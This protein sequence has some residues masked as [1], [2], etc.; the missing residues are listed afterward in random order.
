MPRGYRLLLPRFRVYRAILRHADRKRTGNCYASV[1]IVRAHAE[2]SLSFCSPSFFFFFVRDINRKGYTN[3][4]RR[5]LFL[6][7][8]PS[9]R[10]DNGVERARITPDR[11]SRTDHYL[12]PLANLPIYLFRDVHT[13]SVVYSRPDPY[14]RGYSEQPRRLE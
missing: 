14:F 4:P 1:S 13:R 3:E 8:S 6:R 7:A 2:V 10:M 9:L 12:I 11:P 5:P